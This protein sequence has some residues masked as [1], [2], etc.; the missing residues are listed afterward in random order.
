[1]YEKMK[2]MENN[3]VEI[4]DDPKERQFLM[5]TIKKQRQNEADKEYMQPRNLIDDFDNVDDGALE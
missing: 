2:I 3:Q 4:V 1:M 5:E